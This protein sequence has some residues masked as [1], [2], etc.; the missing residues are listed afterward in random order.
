MTST[1]NEAD[2]TREPLGG[3]GHPQFLGDKLRIPQPLPLL[4]RRRIKPDRAGGAAPGD[5]GVRA[6]RGR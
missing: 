5:P 2:Q 1:I 3:A 6:G 4:R